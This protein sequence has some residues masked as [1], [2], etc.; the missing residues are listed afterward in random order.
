MR[1]IREGDPL[2]LLFIVLAVGAGASCKNATPTTPTTTT[3]TTVAAATVSGVALSGTNSLTV[4]GQTTQLTAAASYSDGTTQNVSP[5]ASWQTDNPAVATVDA[6]LVTAVSSGQA[7]ITA[8][9]QG[10]SGTLLIT[11]SLPN[12][13]IP[14]WTVTLTF[15][16]NSG[17]S[18]GYIAQSRITWSEKG[19]SFGYDV[20]SFL[21]RYL[22]EQGRL[23]TSQT[24]TA[25]SIRNAW[26]GSA[27]IAPGGSKAW[28][29]NF[30]LTTASP[31][32]RLT[33][34]YEST[35][36][37]ERANAIVLTD[38]KTSTLSAAI[39]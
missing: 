22:D 32:T 11:V 25:E 13:A 23:L 35:G 30:P 24:W 17:S 33:A 3:T 36:V 26:G 18:G 7:T 19:G 20:T 29:I 16:T 28:E 12:K 21:I 38:Q 15:R 31:L 6:G 39:R 34:Q 27:R 5:Q 10:K 9:F 37:D 2:V 8:T 1:N 4:K 14:E